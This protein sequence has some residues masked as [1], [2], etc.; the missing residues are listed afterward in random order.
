MTWEVFD[1]ERYGVTNRWGKS[2]EPRVSVQKTGILTLNKAAFKALG[3][4]DAVVLL[5]DKTSR[6]LAFRPASLENPKAFAV[7]RYGAASSYSVYGLPLLKHYGVDHS[8]SRRYRATMTE[9]LLTVPI[10]RDI[11]GG[12]NRGLRA[13]S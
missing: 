9:G 10:E 4:P 12:A 3:E 11:S 2:T 5:F 7:K 6:V 8:E 1:R 13:V